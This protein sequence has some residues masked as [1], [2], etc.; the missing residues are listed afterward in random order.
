MALT[1]DPS[2]LHSPLVVT[3][4]VSLVRSWVRSGVLGCWGFGV[5]GLFFVGVFGVWGCWF[6]FWGSSGLGFWVCWD[7]VVFR[8]LMVGDWG[9]VGCAGFGGFW[10]L[11]GWWCFGFGVGVVFGGL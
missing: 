11:W 10:R 4:L 2:S 3:I 9:F 6:G 8:G 7:L 1:Q 5:V